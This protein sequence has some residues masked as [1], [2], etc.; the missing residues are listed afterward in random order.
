MSENNASTDIFVTVDLGGTLIRAAAYTRAGEQ[1]ARIEKTTPAAGDSILLLAAIKDAI[2]EVWQENVLAV[3]IGAPGPL[4][5]QAGIIL[6]A[7]NLPGL[8]NFPLARELSSIFDCSVYLGND[9]NL[10]ALAEWRFGAGRGHT[11][12][13]YLTI[14]TGIGGG[15]ISG[16]G[17]LTGKAGLAAEL[18]HVP[19][20]EGG[21]LCGCGQHGHLEAVAA[22]QAIARLAREQISAG[23]KSQ[24][25]ELID[26][27][28]DEIT[29]A[30]V[31]QA[32]KAD[33]QLA[34]EVLATAGGAIGRALAGFAHSFNPGVIVLGGGVIGSGEAILRPIRATFEREI[35]IPEY[36]CPVV[37]AALGKDVG[38]LGALVL[39][40]ENTH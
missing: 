11:D 38:L 30:H 10:A 25:M 2:R 4:N 5:S 3:G 29:A 32:A 40:T 28:E 39:A 36:H 1:V 23:V 9:A 18:G 6:Q 24:I 19:V 33:D 34:L 22:G 16:G 37:T 7:P 17:L 12:L 8:N 15:V 20:M 26:G 35:I 31:G 13:L 21:P 14:S 27:D